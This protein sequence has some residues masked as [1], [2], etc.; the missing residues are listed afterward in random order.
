MILN[1][2]VAVFDI[3]VKG[4]SVLETRTTATGNENPQ[5]Q[6]RV[7]F[8]LD[9]LAN[10]IRRSVGED[11]GRWRRWCCYV[12]V[13]EFISLLLSLYDSA[14]NCRRLIDAS[15]LFEQGYLTF[16]LVHQ[17]TV[18]F[19]ANR[20]FDQIVIH[21]TDDSCCRPEFHALSRIYIAAHNTMQ[22]DIRN[23]HSAFNVTIL[24]D[25]ERRI[26]L[27]IGTDIA[28]DGTI[29]MAA[30][31]K[32]QVSVD[33]ELAPTSVSTTVCLRSFRPNM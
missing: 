17:F 27:R 7:V 6:L 33:L 8:F 2:A 25:A 14:A 22:D 13:C 11:D 31:F 24:A 16:R 3:L 32:I 20:H 23:R 10:F 28:F 12:G 15:R 21:I 4:E 26:A 29:N 18:N 30:T 9:Q 5:H 19:G 1:L